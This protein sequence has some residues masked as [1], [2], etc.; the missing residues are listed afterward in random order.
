MI[1]MIEVATPSSPGRSSY[2]KPI[3]GAE[4]LTHV[5]V[6]SFYFISCH[7]ISTIFLPQSLHEPRELSSICTP[8]SLSLSSYTSATYLSQWID[9]CQVWVEVA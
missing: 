1:E 4:D 7:I 8:R 3:K 9:G 2:V 6:A 5:D